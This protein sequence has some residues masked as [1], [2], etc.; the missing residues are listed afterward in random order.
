MT[1][2]LRSRRPFALALLYAALLLTTS[3]FGRHY[4]DA[5]TA[6]RL[7]GVTMGVLMVAWANTLPKMLVPLHRLSCNPAREQALRRFAG[8]A[9]VLGSLGYTLAF[10]LAPIA[11]AATLAMCLLAPT[12][13]AV[14]AIVARCAWMRRRARRVDQG[15]AS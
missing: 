14:A 12:V 4:L 5:A 9:M 7:N 6:I 8:W 11:I 2:S 3:L 10:A 1:S 15:E 13:V